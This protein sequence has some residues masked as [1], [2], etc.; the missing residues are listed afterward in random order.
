MSYF[1]CIL[2][3]FV[4][5]AVLMAWYYKPALAAEK[6]VV[7][8]LEVSAESYKKHYAELWDRVRARL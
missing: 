1:Y 8:H 7:A 3:G 6:R 4:G 2:G 5:G